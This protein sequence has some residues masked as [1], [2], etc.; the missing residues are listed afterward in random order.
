MSEGGGGKLK[1]LTSKNSLRTKG[2]DFGDG[3]ENHTV[4]C[5]QYFHVSVSV[6]PNGLDTCRL[7]T[8][9]QS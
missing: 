5:G 3:F 7:Q 2:F 1:T 8:T 4:S 6:L 9:E